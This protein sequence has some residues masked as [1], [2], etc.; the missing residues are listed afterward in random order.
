V[1]KFPKM[2]YIE[3]RY[4]VLPLHAKVTEEHVRYIADIIKKGW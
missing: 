3:Q 1:G 2:D 4:I